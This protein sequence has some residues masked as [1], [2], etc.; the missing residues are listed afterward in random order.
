M[1]R[2][3]PVM[4]VLLDDDGDWQVLCG[5]TNDPAEGMLVCLGC[6][7]EKNPEIGQFSDLKPGYEA[8]R[9]TIESDWVIDKINWDDQ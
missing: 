2:N 3:Y 6:A 4:A 8:W 1:E 5:Q 9:E 7:Y